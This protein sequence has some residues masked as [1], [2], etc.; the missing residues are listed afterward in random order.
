MGLKVVAL[1]SPAQEPFSA[2]E[3]PL[4]ASSAGRREMLEIEAEVGASSLAVELS[5]LSYDD[6]WTLVP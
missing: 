3:G 2:Q 6:R 5:A 4:G 1:M